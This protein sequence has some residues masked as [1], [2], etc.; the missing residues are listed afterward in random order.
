MGV[1]RLNDVLKPAW[2]LG[3]QFLKVFSFPDLFPGFAFDTPVYF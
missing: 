1:N 3:F 2:M